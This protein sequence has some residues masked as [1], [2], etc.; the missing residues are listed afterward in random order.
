MSF[1]FDDFGGFDDIGAGC[2]EGRTIVHPLA[3][4]PFVMLPATGRYVPSG[5]YTVQ[6]DDSTHTAL[7]VVDR[8]GGPVARA[9]ITGDTWC[10]PA[11]TPE[12]ESFAESCAVHPQIASCVPGRWV[13]EVVDLLAEEALLAARLEAD[14]ADGLVWCSVEGAER[15]EWLV[16]P[17]L[18]GSEADDRNEIMA[19]REDAAYY[20][21]AGSR[22]PFRQ[23]DRRLI[24]SSRIRRPI[25]GEAS[26]NA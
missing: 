1:D 8:A 23:A 22:H 19:A 11:A 16:E 17:L 7:R 25:R 21:L 18:D 26:D 3:S 6:F 14:A 24:H 9:V 5:E 20:W 15:G 12:G 13:E 4:L 2:H 10:E